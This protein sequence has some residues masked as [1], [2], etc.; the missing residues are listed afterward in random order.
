M[1]PLSIAILSLTMT[2]DSFAVA[3]ARG[4]VERPNLFQSLGIATIFAVVQAM[5][6]VL[7]WGAG[8]AASY[9]I[10]ATDHWIAFV[11]LAGV[12]IHMIIES[13]SQSDTNDARTFTAW[14][15]FAAA[16]G[17][18][19]DAA[20]VGVSLAFLDTKIGVIATS[21]GVATFMVVVVGLTVGR[22]IGV[23]WGAVS[24]AIGGF[25]LII[26]GTKILMEHTGIIGDI[27]N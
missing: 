3:L 26:L 25:V 8:H 22:A 13:V 6:P 23:R 15:L 19:I 5:M 21:I 12:G 1:T 11:L 24:E 4:A 14:G 27:I 2:A 18:S 17:T 7:G 16:V 20:A 9:Y 10:K